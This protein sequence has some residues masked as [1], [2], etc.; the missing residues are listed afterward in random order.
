MSAAPRSTQWSGFSAVVSSQ[1]MTQAPGSKPRCA[2]LYTGHVNDFTE[3][4]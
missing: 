3:G 4:G 2:V 1:F